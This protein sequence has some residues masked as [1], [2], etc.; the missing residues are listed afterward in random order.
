SSCRGSGRRSRAARAEAVAKGSFRTL[1]DLRPPAPAR[2][3]SPVL[4]DLLVALALPGA[5]WVGQV[6][7]VRT[8]YEPLLVDRY[9]FERV[10]RGRLIG[11]V[12]D[13]ALISCLTAPETSNDRAP[14]GPVVDVAN[15]LRAMW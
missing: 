8:F 11:A 6:G 14:R 7:R 3:A 13:G 9:R 2:E 15:K 12:P 5:P 10:V 1:A 4:C